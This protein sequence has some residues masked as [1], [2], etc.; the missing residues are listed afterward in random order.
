MTATDPVF[1]ETLSSKRTEALFVALT[2]LF[3]LLYAW[4]IRASGAGFLSAVFLFF[5]VFFLFYAIN[6]RTLRI[7]LTPERFKLKFGIFTWTVPLE[8][9]E[10]CTR[11]DLPLTRIGGAG[12]HFTSIRRRYRV[13]FN[14]LE[15]PR[16]VLA[17]KK[18]Q[19]PVRDVVFSTR[20]PEEFERLINEAV[21]PEEQ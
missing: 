10:S 8:N 5:C 1:Q 16:L 9:I 12:I 19:G 7:H 6:Y 2:A 21:A 18:K 15:Y 13:M 4:R 20:R 17:L 14:F 11:D 3:L